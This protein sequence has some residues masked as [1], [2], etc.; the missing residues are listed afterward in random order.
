ML[1]NFFF[2]FLAREPPSNIS[3][4]SQLTTGAYITK[5]LVKDCILSYFRAPLHQ[6]QEVITSVSELVGFTQDEYEAA[7]NSQLT[8]TNNTF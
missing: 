6:K 4:Y 8:N 3:N 5:Q 7:V 2:W 1:F